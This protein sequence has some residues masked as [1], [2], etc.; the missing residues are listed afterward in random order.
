MINDIENDRAHEGRLQ[1]LSE[2]E[3]VE[4]SFTVQYDDKAVGFMATYI[5][6]FSRSDSKPKRICQNV[7]LLEEKQKLEIRT[8]I[9]LVDL[10]VGSQFLELQAPLIEAVKTQVR[11]LRFDADVVVG[12]FVFF[13]KEPMN[14]IK[15]DWFMEYCA[16]SIKLRK[17]SEAL[18][19]ISRI[20]HSFPSPDRDDFFKVIGEAISPAM[21]SAET[22]ILVRNQRNFEGFETVFS[23][24]GSTIDVPENVPSAVAKSVKDG[25]LQLNNDVLNCRSG[26]PR[27]AV[28]VHNIEFF[29]K[30]GYGSYVSFSILGQDPVFGFSIFCCYKRPYAISNLEVELF[31]NFCLVIEGLYSRAIYSEG[32]RLSEKGEKLQKILKQSLLIADIMHDATEDL[33]FVRNTLGFVR[34]NNLEEKNRLDEAKQILSEIV[35][36]AR[37]FK[38]AISDGIPTFQEKHRKKKPVK[39]RQLV[40]VVLDKYKNSGDYKNI[41]FYNEID[42]SLEIHAVAYSI[43]RAIDNAI[44]NSV[45]HLQS[46]S[47]RRRWIKIQA[48]RLADELEL[49]IHDNGIGM[50]AEQE[51]RCKELLYSSTAG[52]GFGM[53]IIEAVAIAHKGKL[54]V[55]TKHGRYCKLKIYLEYR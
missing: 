41:D 28:Q 13:S 4:H 16:D 7:G 20:S 49:Q 1:A 45:K 10:G 26:L 37:S 38:D 31:E 34:T 3:L 42:S 43:R 9:D 19:Y 36:A 29:K 2:L 24:D 17:K 50:S 23:S 25:S 22:L 33:V 51:S 18:S 46:I 53:S 15:I 44:K 21:R 5:P 8:Y 6:Q 52:M 55:E 30:K 35:D 54:D 47:H 14:N 27:R 48:R 40:Q 12:V 32:N 11:V 39:L